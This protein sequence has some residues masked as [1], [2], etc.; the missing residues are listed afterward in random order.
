[1]GTRLTVFAAC[2]L[3]VPP[4]VWCQGLI[5]TPNPVTITVPFGST[6]ATQTVNITNNGSPIAITNVSTSGQSWLSAFISNTGVVTVTAN[7][8]GLSGSY[9][10]PV[11][12]NSAVGSVNVPVNLNVGTGGGTLGLM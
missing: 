1:M 12:V 10:G 3:I 4:V 8:S 6:T 5:A 11:F 2:L 9:T 7:P